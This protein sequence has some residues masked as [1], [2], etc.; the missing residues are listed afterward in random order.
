MAIFQFVVSSLP[1]GFLPLVQFILF[2][3]GSSCHHGND[4]QQIYHNAVTGE[5]SLA[6]TDCQKYLN[7]G[8]ADPYVPPDAKPETCAYYNSDF[9][10]FPVEYKEFLK[11]FFLAQIDGYEKGDHGLGKNMVRE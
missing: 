8:F 9:S 2:H 7:G 10:S 11:S 4:V 3:I 5:F 6:V 1:I